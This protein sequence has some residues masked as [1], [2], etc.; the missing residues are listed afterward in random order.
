[1]LRTATTGPAGIARYICR[2]ESA[3][4]SLEV[5]YDGGSPSPGN[6]NPVETRV[7]VRGMHRANAHAPISPWVESW[8]REFGNI[9]M[10]TG[11]WNGIKLAEVLR[12]RAF[13]GLARNLSEVAIGSGVTLWEVQTGNT[14][15]YSVI[16]SM[17][18]DL[19]IVFNGYNGFAHPRRLGNIA[20]FNLLGQEVWRV[21]LPSDGDIFAN[22]PEY[23]GGKL[24]SASWEGWTC[25]INDQSGQIL[26]REFTK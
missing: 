1:M 9:E 12:G 5:A 2:A 15:I 20:A 21:Q 4:F 11:A 25:T 13:L 24:K 18:G 17:D 8:V 7:T 3:D 23:L 22:P 16:H 6:A 19:L 14:A 26:A 10:P